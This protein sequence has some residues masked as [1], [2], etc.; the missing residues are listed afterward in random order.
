MVASTRLLDVS[1][2]PDT[3]ADF[4]GKAIVTTPLRLKLGT[5]V[6]LQ[7]GAAR[8]FGQDP[9]PAI[10]SARDAVTGAVVLSVDASAQHRPRTFAR[11]SSV[12]S[13]NAAT[14]AWSRCFRSLATCPACGTENPEGF[15]FCGK[16]GT[17]L[18]AALLPEERKVVTILFCDLK[19]S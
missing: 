8:A 3:T 10:R 9:D 11:M 16:C 6:D 1:G 7:R 12:S 5:P 2:K 19:G 13:T 15:N 14:T 18:Q 4:A 17:P